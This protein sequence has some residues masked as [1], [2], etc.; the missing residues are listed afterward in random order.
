MNFTNSPLVTHTH[1]SPNNYGLRTHVIDTIS[2]H[3]VVGHAS[4]TGLGNWF[5]QSSVKASSN[6]GIDDAGNIGMFVEEKNA[7]WCTSN[8]VNDQR[9]VTIEIA[10]DATSPYAISD[11]ALRGLIKLC[12][13]VCKRNG[14][15][16][17]LW[18]ADEKLLGQVDRQNVSVHRWFAAKACP[19]DY[20][21]SKLSYV[22]DEVNKILGSV[23]VIPA[24]DSPAI[25]AKSSSGL[26]Y[27][28]KINATVL[29]YRNGPGTKYPVVGQVLKGEIYTII[30][31][32]FGLG[33]SKWGRLKSGA[34]WISL[35][36]CTKV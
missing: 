16:K 34:G 15:P 27:K 2:P 24:T 8:R 1:L 9:A 6:Y 29:H 20:L 7:S 35:D 5:A 26:P 4:L 21:Y 32:A 28:V 17:L 22:A 25:P 10:S 13:D 30:E 18:E 11:A 31:E 23:V 36:Y 33:A 3:V 19:G 12:V 14:I